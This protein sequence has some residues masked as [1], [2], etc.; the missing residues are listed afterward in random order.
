MRRRT[1][2][3]HKPGRVTKIVNAGPEEQAQIQINPTDP[4]YGEIRIANILH[5]SIGK[6]VRLQKDDNVDLVIRTDEQ[7]RSRTNDRHRWI[8][9]WQ[10]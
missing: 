2:E 10:S 7:T 9:A 4:V 6:S 3:I 5:D 1:I 8:N